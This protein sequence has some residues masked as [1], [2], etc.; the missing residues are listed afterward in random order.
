MASLHD[1]EMVT[2]TGETE[3]LAR[4]EGRACLVVN[5]ASR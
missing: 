1:F 2:I 4:Y 3:S 5:L